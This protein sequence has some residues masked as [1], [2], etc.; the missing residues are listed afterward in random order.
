MTARA[1]LLVS[2]LGLLPA[3]CYYGDD[4][5][6]F[7]TAGGSLL[8]CDNFEE[9]ALGG[10]PRGWTV[11]G[12]TWSVTTPLGDDSSHVLVQQQAEPADRR[13][14]RISIA[15]SWTD[16]TV[17]ARIWLPVVDTCG[18]EL[19]ARYVDSDHNYEL[20]LDGSGT[21]YAGKHDGTGLFAALDAYATGM[22]VLPGTS[23][24]GA[25]HTLTLT[26]RG[27]QLTARSTAR[28]SSAPPTRRSR[29]AAS[30]SAAA[31]PRAAST[32]CAS[33]PPDVNP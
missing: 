20:A 23:K 17:S 24:I 25:W 29:A 33:R 10:A 13:A 5:A 7:C 30:R 22:A 1:A 6:R 15:G 11:E 27:T 32:T 12:G 19:F 9:D 8:F 16:V 28:S 14:Y 4:F 21:A 26:V 31:Y 3:G 2:A 18:S